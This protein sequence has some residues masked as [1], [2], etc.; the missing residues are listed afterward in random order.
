MMNN[1]APRSVL[2]VDSTCIKLDETFNLIIYNINIPA[3]YLQDRGELT[4]ILERVRYVLIRD[5]ST[6]SITYQITASYILK[7]SENGQQKTW[8]GSTRNGNLMSSCQSSSTFNANCPEINPLLPIEDTENTLPFLCKDAILRLPNKKKIL[9][10]FHT[11]ELNINM[12]FI[13]F[14][15]KHT[16]DLVQVQKI[17]KI[18]F[19][20]IKR[21]KHNL[22]S[23]IYD[24]RFFKF[25]Q[26]HWKFQCWILNA[27][28]QFLKCCRKIS[29]LPKIRQQKIYKSQKP[30]WKLLNLNREIPDPQ[31][32]QETIDFLHKY[33]KA[34]NVLLSFFYKYPQYSDIWHEPYIVKDFISIKAFTTKNCIIAFQLQQFQEPKEK[35]EK[36]MTNLFH[37]TSN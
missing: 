11:H 22:H 1:H 4:E 16:L 31:S 26:N 21:N 34:N 15:N 9:N 14:I 35:K 3:H 7:H 18:Q 27:N 37:Y 28:N 13:D 5:F 6:F 25:I 20:I 8:C 2:K 10:Y 17:A 30:L 19:A 24:G 32:R 23:I 36:L 33:N 12:I 29:R